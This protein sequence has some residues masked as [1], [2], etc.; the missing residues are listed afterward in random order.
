[1]HLRSTNSSTMSSTPRRKGNENANVA[2]NDVND[3]D[4]ESLI[5]QTISSNILAMPS[6]AIKMNGNGNGAATNAS[7]STHAAAGVRNSSPVSTGRIFR[8]SATQM[9]MNIIDSPR[10]VLMNRKKMR[11]N[12]AGSSSERGGAKHK[13]ASRSGASAGAGTAS[14]TTAKNYCENNYHSASLQP[15]LHPGI[16]M[17][18]ALQAAVTFQDP[19]LSHNNSNNNNAPMGMGLQEKAGM[20]MSLAASS[21]MSQNN[22]FSCP[23]PSRRQIRYKVFQ[24]LQEDAP[25]DIIPKV[26]SFAGPQMMQ[27]LSRVNTFWRDECTSEAVFRTLC[28]DT[29]KW[30]P[31]KHPEPMSHSQLESLSSYSELETV[32]EAGSETS[33]STSGSELSPRNFHRTIHLQYSNDDDDQ[34]VHTAT[35]SDSESE[36]MA[37]NTWREYY[38]NNPIVPLDYRTI[39]NALAAVCTRKRHQE[40]V[41]YECDRN[42]RILLHPTI[43]RMKKRII[44]ETL[45]EATF[46]M[47]TH[48]HYHHTRFDFGL[49]IAPLTVTHRNRG[50]TSSDGSI[51]STSSF[52]SLGSSVPDGAPVTATRRRLNSAGLREIFTC[53]SAQGAEDPMNPTSLLEH[54][55]SLAHSRPRSRRGRD[56]TRTGRDRD[57]GRDDSSQNSGESSRSQEKNDPSEATIILK[58]RKENTPIF[59]I[60]QGQ[61]RLSKLNLLHDCTGTDIWNGNTAVQIQPRCN[62]DRHHRPIIPKQPHHSP[63][64]IIEHSKVMSVSGRGI[65]AIDGSAA[66]VRKCYI[67]KCAATGIYVGGRGSTATVRQTDIVENGIGNTSIGGRRNQRGRVIARGHSG[68]YLE[69]GLAVLRDCNISQNALTGLSAVSP[70]NAILKISESDIMCN[71]TLQLELP[72]QGS[73]SFAKAKSINNT[74]SADGQPRCRSGLRP[75]AGSVV[76]EEETEEEV[77]TSS[78]EDEMEV[79]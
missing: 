68:V 79:H 58:T 44:V 30:I 29:G 59:H 28:E 62:E 56:G 33:T 38:C 65:V 10:R 46:H 8:N 75:Y 39:P 6:T 3:E 1:M 45:G 34:D 60:R 2:K 76:S 32:S 23:S 41:Y 49:G 22:A 35:D 57:R 48:I 54:A 5:L 9:V 63:S 43:Y 71:G 64:C 53:R 12:S 74:I 21:H 70:S 7:S 50:R 40:H 72:A 67:Y 42:V 18:D 26:L 47:E 27:I 69:Q 66:S 73:N 19:S 77:R 36:S 55:H 31:G 15:Y 14:I 11:L 37:C 61:M 17:P 25:Q 52:L 16:E 51:S 24:W 78:N 13:N 20:Y 4:D